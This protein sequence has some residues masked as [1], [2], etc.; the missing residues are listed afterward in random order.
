MKISYGSRLFFVFLFGITMAYFEAAVVVYLRALY[1]PSGF[2]LPLVRMDDK[3]MAV[4]L[5]REA[6]SI[7]MI[8]SVSWL[9]G[10]KFWERFGYFII[11]FGTWDI[12]YYVWLK[13]IL[14]WPKS[15]LEPD[16]LYL[17]PY[18]WIGPVIAPLIVSVVMIII[19][20]SITRL[21]ER[22]Q[23]FVPS[24]LSWILVILGTFLILFS[25]MYDVDASLYQ[26]EPRPYFYWMLISGVTLYIWAYLQSYKKS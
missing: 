19:G 3:T 13:A 15:L 26:A 25:F 24:A 12:F 9:A 20:I 18:P 6:A 2:N 17:I 23:K 22:G 5:F 21:F 7:F 10:K 14:N 16:V 8:I 4:E 1:Y 11:I